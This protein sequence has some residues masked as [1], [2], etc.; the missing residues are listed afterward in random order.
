MLYIMACELH[1]LRAI[2]PFKKREF[3]DILP[4]REM[5][6]ED[7]ETLQIQ[8]E[9]FKTVVCSIGFKHAR[10]LGEPGEGR[11]YLDLSTMG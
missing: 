6:Q 7:A 8:L 1:P 3:C 2:H 4:A 5:P 10:R 11:E 9:C